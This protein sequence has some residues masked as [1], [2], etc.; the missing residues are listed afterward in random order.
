MRPR[1]ALFYKKGC[2]YIKKRTALKIVFFV[3]FSILV[4]V[5]AVPLSYAADYA[6]ANKVAEF[7]FVD[8]QTCID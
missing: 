2:D 1:V 6:L 7:K 5:V 4:L 8:V 3:I